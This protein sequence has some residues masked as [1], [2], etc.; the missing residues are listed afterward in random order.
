M[1]TFSIVYIS[2]VVGIVLQLGV[3][4]HA[5]RSGIFRVHP[6]FVAYSGIVPACNVFNLVLL[7][8]LHFRLNFYSTW[9]CEV[10]HILLAFIVI[11]EIL[12]SIFMEYEGIRKLGMYLYFASAII[13]VILGVLAAAMTKAHGLPRVYVTWMRIDTAVRV[14]QCGLV[15]FLVFFM[16][17][18]ALK[19]KR[20]SFGIALGY[21]FYACL[22]LMYSVAIL[23]LGVE[24]NVYLDP[25]LPAA[26]L[27]TIMIWM[28]AAMA[29]A[30]E[31]APD[32]LPQLRSIEQWDAAILEF[33]RR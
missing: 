16:R 32:E 21:G 25:I 26:Y 19:W 30:R 2:T 27:V 31:L 29:P 22:F 17:T 1:L 12:D 24:W 23:H 5:W 7:A 20:R 6:F 4:I 15:L 33:L 3:F 9:L 8:T 18:L 28:V 11:H 14:V 10:V 13:L